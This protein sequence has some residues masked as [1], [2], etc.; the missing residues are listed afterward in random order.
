ME[1]VINRVT[2]DGTPSEANLKHG[3]ESIPW[4]I[5]LFDK[6]SFNGDFDIFAEIN[7]YWS[8]LP[9]ANQDKIF[10]IYR[11]TKEVFNSVYEKKELTHQLHGLVKELY[12][13]HELADIKH[14]KDFQSNLVLPDGLRDQ[15]ST[16]HETPGTRERTYLKEDYH[17]LVTL[18]I[19]IRPMIPIWGQ[20]IAHT[21][22]EAG[23]TFKEYYALDLL[24]QANIY[25]SEPMERLRVYVTH[26]IPADKSL[27]SAILGG[28]SS[29][30]VPVWM[31]GLV[32]I[33]RLSVGDVRGIDPTSSL[34]TF[35]YKYIGQKIKGH[36]NSFIGMVKEKPFEAHGQEG[37]A[38]LSRLEGY[39]VKQ[40]IAAGDIA[41]IAY[42]AQ[43]V[44]NLAKL[45]CPD[46]DLAL[47]R[48]SEQ[49]VAIL[50]TEQIWEPQI[51]LMQWVLKQKNALPPRGLLH[52]P[53]TDILRCMAVTQALLWHRGHFE[54]AAL[55]SATEQ[56]NAD[57]LQ[58][59]GTDSRSRIPKEML[60]EIEALYPYS[61]RPTGKGKVIKRINPAEEAITS[62]DKLF[63]ERAWILTLPPDWV[64]K[65]TGNRNN[66]RWAVPQD[67]RTKLA[68]LIIS[69]ANRTF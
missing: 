59:I 6:M 25:R 34:V 43:D 35:I 1:L 38:N 68:A 5:A 66:R 58:L 8:H 54:L 56:S 28:L 31:L 4:N 55:L 32:V 18:S 7:G 65:I 30:D 15:F 26:S 49:S 2:A 27:A 12:T 61:R 64:M 50:A 47:V 52:L 42:Y 36:D 19:A 24:S 13:Y 23:T 51:V 20:F 45:I 29:E 17:W 33:R 39:K 57:E 9:K 21:K 40:E 16:S 41:V 22:K 3:N 63:T 69:L 11:R 10:D 67:I 37:E 48:M 62:M 44:D 60:E 53:K 14:W 46:I